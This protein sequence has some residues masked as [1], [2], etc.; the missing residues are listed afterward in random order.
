MSNN[1]NS[2]RF[3]LAHSLLLFSSIVSCSGPDNPHPPFHHHHHQRSPLPFPKSDSKDLTQQLLSLDLGFNVLN[4]QLLRESI[5]VGFHSNQD[6]NQ[7]RR[8]GFD[9]FFIDNGDSDDDDI[10]GEFLPDASALV[11]K[12]DFSSG[13]WNEHERF[14]FTS[15]S[16]SV[17]RRRPQPPRDKFFVGDQSQCLTGSCEFFLFC[18]LQGGVVE[19]GCGGFLM[20]CCNK[21][22]QVGHK[23]IVTQV[24]PKKF[25]TLIWTGDLKVLIYVSLTYSRSK[26]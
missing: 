20:S 16:P 23:A 19:G 14:F 22:N 9:A 10:F 26:R 24:G 4:D 15:L 21:P 25:E 13:P 6:N 17:S 5:G 8:D 3:P 12:D 1:I 7:E 18:W 11:S 2:L